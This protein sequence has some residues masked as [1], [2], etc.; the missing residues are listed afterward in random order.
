MTTVVA[1]ATSQAIANRALLTRELCVMTGKART[2]RLQT[3][4]T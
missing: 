2:V 4:T 3:D 1:V